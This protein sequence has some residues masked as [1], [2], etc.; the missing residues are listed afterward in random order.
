MILNGLYF[1]SSSSTCGGCGPPFPSPVA[2]W[3]IMYWVCVCVCVCVC[4][5][6]RAHLLQSLYLDWVGDKLLLSLLLLLA[7][8]EEGVLSHLDRHVCY[9]VGCV[10]AG[11]Q[12]SWAGGQSLHHK[13][14]S[15]WNTFEKI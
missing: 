10:W 6:V 12:C 4:V 3:E 13:T 11:E 7:D 1:S 2:V 8:E 5:Y 15:Q 9:R 14:V